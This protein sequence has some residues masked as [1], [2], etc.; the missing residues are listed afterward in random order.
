M[1]SQEPWKYPSHKGGAHCLKYQS[2]HN[3]YSFAEKWSRN[4][5]INE[6]FQPLYPVTAWMKK[7]LQK[8]RVTAPAWHQEVHIT[9]LL[10]V[11]KAASEEHNVIGVLC[12]DLDCR[13]PARVVY[14]ISIKA[15]IQVVSRE[16]DPVHQICMQ[17][18]HC[19]VPSV[20]GHGLSYWVWYHSIPVGQR[21]YISSEH[22]SEGFLSRTWALYLVV[23]VQLMLIWWKLYT[24]LS[25]C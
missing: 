24:L 1:L 16:K 8:A 23:F 14:K 22:F 6:S 7:L 11:L 25:L 4:T 12:G 17:E 15:N 9:I 21:E 20:A 2:V 3:C 10:F 18:P 5:R 19:Q 13:L